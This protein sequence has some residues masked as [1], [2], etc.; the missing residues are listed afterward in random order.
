MLLV[1]SLGSNIGNKTENLL[2]ACDKLKKEIGDIILQSQFYESEPWGVENQENYYNAVI[3]INADM[4]PKE[5]KDTIQ[6]IEK[7][8]G[9]EYNSERWHSRII[10]IDLIYADE[11]IYVTRDFQIPHKRMHLRNFVLEPLC[12]I[13]PDM[14]HPVFGKTSIELLKN[15]PDQSKVKVIAHAG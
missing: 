15:C 5:I 10:D 2:E 9:R 7:E 8:I 14:L 3:A 6:G 12:E 13:L 1:F 11:L 4:K